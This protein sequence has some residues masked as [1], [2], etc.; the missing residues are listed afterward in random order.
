MTAGVEEIGGDEMSH[1]RKK[2]GHRKDKKVEMMR[3]QEAL[4]KAEFE[5][6]PIHP[7][8]DQWDVNAYKPGSARDKNRHQPPP[9]VV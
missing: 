5:Q 8:T 4:R 1:E 9:P 2:G 6:K 7:T 3:T